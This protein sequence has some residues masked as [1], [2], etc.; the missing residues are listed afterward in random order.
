ME[1]E[2]IDNFLEPENFKKLTDSML[3]GFFPWYITE[4][5]VGNK[6]INTNQCSFSHAFYDN[7]RIHS[8][9]FQN[10]LVVID[11]LQIKSLL[12]IKSNLYPK[13]T[14]LIEHDFH[15]DYDFSHKGILLYFNTNDGYTELHDGTKIESIENRAMFFDPGKQH[16][17]TNCTDQKAR[18][19]LNVNYL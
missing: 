7:Y 1:Y 13:T 18:F 15:S 6:N 16:R 9:Y 14:Q 12:R 4:D 19:N 2:V 5:I 3:G 17:S 10:L 11:K 8:D